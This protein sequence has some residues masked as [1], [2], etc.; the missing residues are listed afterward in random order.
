MPNEVR[1]VGLI[2]LSRA[3]TIGL[4]TPISA[5][6]RLLFTSW[7]ATCVSFAQLGAMSVV[8]KNAQELAL[9]DLSIALT[10]AAPRTDVLRVA[11]SCTELVDLSRTDA[12]QGGTGRQPVWQ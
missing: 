12:S 2:V 9:L 3:F 10:A 1:C 5:L 8:G 11:D 7:P 6:I 4:T